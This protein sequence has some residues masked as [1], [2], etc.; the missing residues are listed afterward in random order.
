[1]AVDAVV[2]VKTPLAKRRIKREADTTEGN[3]KGP[4]HTDSEDSP[5]K[6]DRKAKRKVEIDEEVDQEADDRKRVKRKRKTEKEA[7]AMPLAART[8][9]QTLKKAMY[10]GAHIS[11]AGC[12]NSHTRTEC[13]ALLP[14]N[15]SS[16]FKF[17]PVLTILSL[18]P[19][20]TNLLH[21][22]RRPL[23]S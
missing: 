6:V 21:V 2:K 18:F 16:V 23:L 17:T 10:I 9:I 13:I 15:S 12:K 14:S 5:K 19:T 4:I 22:N 7:E 1:M 20:N 11:G 8:S 3:I